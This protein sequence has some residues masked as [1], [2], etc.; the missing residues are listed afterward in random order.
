MRTKMAAMALW[1]M[2]MAGCATTTHQVETLNAGPT[3]IS[4]TPNATG[5]LWVVR[6]TAT[7]ARDVETTTRELTTDTTKA[8]S[9]Y[10]EVSSDKQLWLC[11]HVAV[12]SRPQCFEADWFPGT[13]KLEPSAGGAAP[14][15][16]ITCEGLNQ[17]CTTRTPP[18]E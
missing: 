1:A 9:N 17:N 11:A 2:A 13:A 10:V 3:I 14:R 8:F 16:V 5:G 12:G 7:F 18:A 4:V 15:Q 6:Q